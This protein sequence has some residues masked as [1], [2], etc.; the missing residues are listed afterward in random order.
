[1]DVQTYYTFSYAL[2]GILTLPIVLLTST[3]LVLKSLLRILLKPTKK[4]PK[5]MSMAQIRELVCDSGD[6]NAIKEAAASFVSLFSHLPDI[7]D[8][9][10]EQEIKQKLDLVKCVAANEALDNDYIAKFQKDLI[11]RNPSYKGDIT[12][13]VTFALNAR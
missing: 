13:I 5:K 8:K 2:L 9:D 10:N 3:I 6:V 1:M 12:K 11:E 4:A 7:D